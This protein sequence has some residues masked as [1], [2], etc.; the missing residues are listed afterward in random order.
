MNRVFYRHPA[1]NAGFTLIELLVVIAIIAILAGLLLPALSRAK[2]KA[3]AIKCLGNS[4]QIMTACQL[5]ISDNDDRFPAVIQGG[6]AQNPVPDNPDA[7]W[8]VGW[9]DWGTRTDNTNVLYLID[10]KY[11]K[12][13]AY[14][15]NAREILKCPADRYLSSVQRS[16]GWRERVRSYSA[17]MAVG[18]GNA[19][20]GPFDNIY[21]HARKGSDLVIPGPAETFVYLDE[22]PDSINDGG[23]FPP[24]AT[25]WVDLPGNLHG[26][27]AALAFADGHSELHK[28][29]SSV[30]NVPVKLQE[31]SG[32]TAKAGDR[33]IAWLSYRT[34][35][36]TEKYF[37]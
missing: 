16:Q 24:K 31:Y 13:A 20:T 5:F 30:A 19:E 33:D 6:E 8:V 29:R 11:S 4:K 17:S 27:V 34:P 22:H 7:P 1:R 9:L 25:G 14:F 10:P 32:T 23:F 21:S 2:Q 37:E 26:K 36:K 28:W 15:S 3:L 35:R 12:L 18:E